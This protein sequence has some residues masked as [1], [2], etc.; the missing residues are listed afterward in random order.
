MLFNIFRGKKKPGNIVFSGIL[1][2]VLLLFIRS[3]I[4]IYWEFYYYSR[5]WIT[6]YWELNYYFSGFIGS[7]L[8]T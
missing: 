4:T 2:G 8:L 7:W 5:M 3:F 6:I 1:L